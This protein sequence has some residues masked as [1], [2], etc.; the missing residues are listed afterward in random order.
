MSFHAVSAMLPV[1][2]VFGAKEPVRQSFRP[3]RS[4][5][6]FVCLRCRSPL[7]VLSEACWAISDVVLPQQH[8]GVQAIR[9]WALAVTMPVQQVAVSV[10]G[11]AGG[12]KETN[13]NA[14]KRRTAML[15]HSVLKIA[16]AKPLGIALPM[17]VFALAGAWVWR[18]RE[19]L[20]AAAPFAVDG[21]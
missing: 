19:R 11:D 13:G 14:R 7:R 12:P 4:V 17:G 6:D 1:H 5:P 3:R 20:A 8:R 15:E 21:T 18:G 10:L 9:A 2:G 16:A